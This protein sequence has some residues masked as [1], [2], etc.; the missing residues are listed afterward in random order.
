M[1]TTSS[2]RPSRSSA[3]KADGKAAWAARS[4][5]GPHTAQLPSGQE[6][7]FLVPDSNALIRSDRLPDRLME[8]ALMASAYPDGADGYMADLA[9][10]AFRDEAEI[11]KV[12][13][14]V[15][16]GLELRDW[17][18]AHMLV[19]PEV[20]PDEVGSGMFPDAD[21]EMLLEF[22]ERKRCEDAAGVKLPIIVLEK[23]ARF[24]AAVGDSEDA[25]VGGSDGDELPRDDFGPD[26]GD[27]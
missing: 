7:T 10:A 2:T 5:R 11:V 3:P 18:V 21:I 26:P 1:A 13:K 9:V 22:A 14:A 16:D 27:M 4:D 17:L 6:V 25:G 15:K 20:T 12:G 24:P 19:S 23:F 8:I